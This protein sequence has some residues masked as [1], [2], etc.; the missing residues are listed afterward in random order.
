MRQLVDEEWERL[1]DIGAKVTTYTLLEIVRSAVFLEE[2]PFP[3]QMIC[4]QN[5]QPLMDQI[6]KHFIERYCYTSMFVQRINNGNKKRSLKF[7]DQL[8][9]SIAFHLGQ[10]ACSFSNGEINE[11][12]FE[13]MD[14]THFVF[15]LDNRKCLSFRGDQSVNYLGIVSGAERMTVVLQVTG[16]VNSRIASPFYISRVVQE[17]T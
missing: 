5:N 9:K 2:A 6:D 12:E 17:A 15:D 7:T 4:P 16:V 11:D 10:I 14:G 8:E 1:R 13:N 3:A